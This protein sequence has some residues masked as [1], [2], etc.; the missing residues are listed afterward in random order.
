MKSKC[1]SIS[2]NFILLCS[3]FVYQIVKKYEYKKHEDRD[4]LNKAMVHLLP[5]LLE[6]LLTYAITKLVVKG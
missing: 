5:V 3:I 1:Q 6:R 4:G 2:I